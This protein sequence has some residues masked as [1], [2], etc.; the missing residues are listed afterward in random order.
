MA[1]KKKELPAGAIQQMKILCIR[2]LDFVQRAREEGVTRTD[3]RRF[4]SEVLDCVQNGIKEIG[5]GKAERR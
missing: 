4:A 3:F 2:S 1:A 5:G